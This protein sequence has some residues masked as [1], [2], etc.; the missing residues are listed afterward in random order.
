MLPL[1]LVPAPRTV[2][3]RPFWLH[4]R[5]VRLKAALVVGRTTSAG[6]TG[7]SGAAS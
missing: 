5:T 7:C 1:R 2:N 4:R 6:G 3:G